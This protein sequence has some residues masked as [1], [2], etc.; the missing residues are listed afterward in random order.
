[1]RT[2]L[3]RSLTLFICLLSLC[4]VAIT[5]YADGYD[6]QLDVPLLPQQTSS[7]C[8]DASAREC[9]AYYYQHGFITGKSSSIPSEAQLVSEYGSGSITPIVNGLRDY[10][11]VSFGYRAKTTPEDFYTYVSNSLRRGNPVVAEV[12]LNADTSWVLGYTTN[13]HYLVISGIKKIG[14]EEYLVITDPWN[15]NGAGIGQVIEV[16][17]VHICN[18]CVYYV[19]E[20][21]GLEIQNGSLPIAALDVCNGYPGSI[22][23]AGWAFDRD[24]VNGTVPVHVYVGGPAGSGSGYEIYADKGREDVD[25]VYSVGIYHGFDSVIEVPLRGTQ[26]VYLYACDIGDVWLDNPQFATATVTISDPYTIEYDSNGGRGAPTSQKK[27]M[28]L[29]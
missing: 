9:I 16:P 18:V 25:A 7:T 11:G 27:H 3:F 19:C 6:I 5:A 14:N 20:Q 26:N 4:S 29:T 21:N 23:V 15:I 12:Y 22:R 13:G 1:M 10:C 24:N 8:A 28:E 17:W 2:S